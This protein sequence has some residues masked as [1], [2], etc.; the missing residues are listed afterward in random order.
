[1]NYHANTKNKITWFGILILSVCATFTL[2]ACIWDRDTLA[3]EIKTSPK[4]ADAI[5][6]PKSAEPDKNKLRARIQELEADRK[7]NDPS[8]WNDLAGAYLRLGLADKAVALLEPVRERF[9]KDYG[10]HANLGTAYH[11]LG[12]Y[13]EAE[14]EIAR[15]LE[16]NPEAHFGLEKY[17]LALLRYLTKDKEYQSKHLYLD[18]F[19]EMLYSTEIIRDSQMH[20]SMIKVR[21]KLKETE[22][23]KQ[24]E[25]NSEAEIRDKKWR[26]I[27]AE[28][29]AKYG[30]YET[31]F[32]EGVIYMATL[33]PKEPACITMLGIAALRN[34]D[35]NLAKSAFEKALSMGSPM[36]D[37]L[38]KK[39]LLI[40][41]HL[42]SGNPAK[43]ENTKATEVRKLFTTIALT[44]T[45]IGLLLTWLI[46]RKKYRRKPSPVHT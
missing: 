16:L 3:D 42:T 10:Y 24:F 26:K 18:E 2:H 9:E 8:W 29:M 31:N 41:A 33:N 7:E 11:L 15:D 38:R 46:V 32:Q 13:V 19:T 35:L 5:L 34:S 20:E 1:M 14:K 17:H 22:G 44:V 27:V 4:L 21:A 30:Q 39:I 6:N 45:G 25:P 37:L 23:L 12:R 43:K 28:Y 36:A 40:D